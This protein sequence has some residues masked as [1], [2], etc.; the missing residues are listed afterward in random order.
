MLPRTGGY[1]RLENDD[2]IGLDGVNGSVELNPLQNSTNSLAPTNNPPNTLKIL[3]KEKTFEITNISGS[4]TIG[5]LKR[6]ILEATEVEL[7]RQRLIMGGKPMRPD[8][9]TLASYKLADN[10]HIHLFP[11]PIQPVN[12]PVATPSATPSAPTNFPYPRAQPAH[13]PTTLFNVEID[14]HHHLTPVHYDAYISHHGREVKMWCIILLFLSTISLF[15]NL[16]YF[17]A[18]GKF[19]H[20]ALDS[21]VFLLDTT[22]SALGLV[23]AS[24][25]LKSVQSLNTTHLREYLQVQGVC[26]LCYR[27][28]HSFVA[29]H[30]L[31]FTSSL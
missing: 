23:V 24:K 20:G 12:L 7:A 14:T 22:C 28:L 8:E 27:S 13:P 16:T 21:V 3:Y 25:G 15:N 11:I 30:S 5:E 19:G 26:K 31:Q 29:L 6:L 18:T 2:N 17:T 1:Q 10:A 4:T 9:A